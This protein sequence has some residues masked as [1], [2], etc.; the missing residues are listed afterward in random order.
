MLKKILISFIVLSISLFII[1][2]FLVSKKTSSYIKEE[3]LKNAEISMDESYRAINNIISS[4][5]DTALEIAINNTVQESLQAINNDLNS[6]VHLKE[7]SG[8]LEEYPGNHSTYTS[9][10]IYISNNNYSS[11]PKN[12]NIYT[13]EEWLDNALSNPDKFLWSLHTINQKTILRQTKCIYSSSDYKNIVGVIAIDIDVNSIRSIASVANETGTRLYLVDDKGNISYP[14]YNYDHIPDE[15]LKANTNSEFE[16]DDNLILVR[17]IRS[18]GWNL[19]KT[20]S[21]SIINDRVSEIYKTIFN[22]VLFFVFLVTGLG[23]IFNKTFLKPVNGLANKMKGV[24]AGELSKIENGPREGEVATLYSSYN[25]MIDR[26]NKEINENYISQIRE[27]DAELRAL[28]AQ[29]N[30]HFLYNTLDSINWLALKYKAKDISKMVISLSDMLRL[31]LNKGKNILNIKEELRQVESYIELQKVRYSDCFD[32]KFEVEED[33]LDR[34]ILKMLLQ[35]LVENA[36]IHGFED[37][38]SGGLII[39]RVRDNKDKTYFEVENNGKIIDL[40]DINSRLNNFES[41]EVRKGYGIINVNE[42]IKALYGE[43]YGINYMI[44]DN[45]TVAY[46]EI[47]IKELSNESFNR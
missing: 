22:M 45:H 34:K 38:E 20:I 14:L 29:I 8:Y 4:A 21:V 2:G 6:N 30:P 9:I 7:V 19:I 24:Q 32:Y 41:E 10:S 37:V 43:E 3:I 13:K 44:R 17:K 12:I 5:K 28:Q 46:F 33:I 27:K 26:I 18:T 1:L 36:L 15:I 40:E 35:P 16:V 47:P 42:R 11:L 25:L 39:I 23:I 31:S